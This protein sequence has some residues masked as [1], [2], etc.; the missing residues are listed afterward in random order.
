LSNGKGN[1]A[2]IVDKRQ[3]LSSLHSLHVTLTRNRN[4]LCDRNLKP[5][6]LVGIS[7]LLQ[8]SD[9]FHV[10]CLRK[11]IHKAEPSDGV[12]SLGKETKIA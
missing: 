8:Q 5:K 11:H 7:G 3:C 2:R 9:D 6:P 4:G 1:E 12:S 10:V